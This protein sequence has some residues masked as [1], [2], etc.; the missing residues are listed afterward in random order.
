MRSTTLIA[1]LPLLAGAST[2]AHRSAETHQQ[3]SHDHH[4]HHHHDEGSIASTRRTG[5]KS[6]G[7]GPVH[8]H[9]RFVTP[10]LDHDDSVSMSASA[11]VSGSGWKVEDVVARIV[12]SIEG[13]QEA[14]EGRDYYIRSDVSLNVPPG[15]PRRGGRGRGRSPDRG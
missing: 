15:V 3:P 6:L 12:R 1:L 14:Q 4:Q 2:L 11:S 5:R 10:E 8:Q 13:L 9:A 7:F